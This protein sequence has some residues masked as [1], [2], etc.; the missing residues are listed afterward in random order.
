MLA[1]AFHDL[2]EDGLVVTAALI[3]ADKRG[4][5]EGTG[6][7]PFLRVSGEKVSLEFRH[8]GEG[9]D[10][11]GAL[12]R[13]VEIPAFAGMTDGRINACICSSTACSP[14]GRP[15]GRETW[16]AAFQRTTVDQDPLRV[17]VA[18]AAV[19]RRGQGDRRGRR[20][21][22]QHG[23]PAAGAGRWRA[24]AARRSALWPRTAPVARH[25]GA[26]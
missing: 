23:R 17:A 4:A 5:G 9:R 25:L 8:P 14:P 22:A 26:R 13:K 6:H 16:R 21:I 18:R 1:A 20:E 12:N 19:R 11:S 24:I 10:P 15:V 2:F 7:R 3:V